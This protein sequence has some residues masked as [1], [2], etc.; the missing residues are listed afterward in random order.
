[1]RALIPPKPRKVLR[2]HAFLFLF[3]MLLFIGLFIFGLSLWQRAG[4]L[5]PD[6]LFFAF[7]KNSQFFLIWR[8]GFYLAVALTWTPVINRLQSRVHNL[9]AKNK[10]QGLK[11]YR[12]LLC[13]VFVFY[14]LMIVQQGFVWIIGKGV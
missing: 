13:V 1:M 7:D 5:S 9:V 12:L 2:R 6:N 11:R 10:L 8:M 4:E 3:S 14:E